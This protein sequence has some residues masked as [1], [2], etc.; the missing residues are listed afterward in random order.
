[1]KTLHTILL[2]STLGAL[3]SCSS[4]SPYVY[5]PYYGYYPV[6]YD[7]AYYDAAMVSGYYY[8]PGYYY[9]EQRLQAAVVNNVPP[10]VRLLLARWNAAY[11]PS[12]VSATTRADNDKDGFDAMSTVTFK[13][14]SNV[15]GRTSQVSGAV[16]V[17]DLDDTVADA[18]YSVTFDQ[19]SIHIV[20]STGAVTDRVWNGTETIQRFP[21]KL[22]L[23]RNVT[24]NATETFPDN[25][26]RASKLE[27]MEEGSFT[28]D[29]VPNATRITGGTVTLSGRSTFT[30]PD[31]AILTIT[32]QTDPTLHWNGDC[33]KE[34]NSQGYDAGAIIYRSSQGRQSRIEHDSCTHVNVT[35]STVP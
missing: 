18:G 23:T 24:V 8:D 21:G 29:V 35:N 34:P 30:G 5:D 11:D 16:T 26:Q 15:D 19:L 6:V 12:C 3:A 22:Q 7:D 32:R 1:M 10:T 17:H 20:S 25:V 31:G 33:V 27:A 4:S 28:P 9:Y 14:S 13:C 2:A